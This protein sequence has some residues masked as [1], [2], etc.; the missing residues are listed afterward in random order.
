MKH[1][2]LV[3]SDVHLGGDLVQHLRPHAPVRP[4]AVVRRDEELVALLDWYSA[5]DAHDGGWRLV[6][7][8]DFIDFS[9][10][11]VGL[12]WANYKGQVNLDD[13][14]FG[15]GSTEQASVAKL[16]QVV[17]AHLEV[18]TALARFVARGNELF[19]VRGNH[20]VD[21]FWPRV[22]VAMRDA[23]QSLAEAASG[24]ALRERVHFSDWFY[25]E[26][27]R[28]FVE[29]G[30]NYDAY[31]AHPFPLVPLDPS[32]GT[33]CARSLSDMLKRYVVNP[34]QGLTE[35]GHEDAG[36][37][38]YLRLCVRLGVRRCGAVVGRFLAAVGRAMACVWM[39]DR[40]ICLRF[41]EEQARMLGELA[42]RH[43]LSRS[44]LDHLS[45]H[46][47]RPGT[48]AIS[49]IFA[50]LML[51]QLLLGIAVLLAWFEIFRSFG[52]SHTSLAA[53]LATTIAGYFG[54]SRLRAGRGPVDASG[55][56]LESARRVANRLTTELVVMGHSHAPAIVELG[57]TA[58]YM[59]L[60]SWAE[61]DP[62]EG[63]GACP[64]SRTHLV[65]PA[66]SITEARLYRWEDG[67]PLEYREQPAAPLRTPEAQLDRN[68]SNVETRPT[69]LSALSPR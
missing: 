25:Y 40:A 60:G 42:E 3:I 11:C 63:L 19:F 34:T 55:A 20:D 61:A 32:D 43:A 44:S 41:A 65:V 4:S 59:N 49:T 36:I 6:I 62:S 50:C 54:S 28:V 56:L 22:Q 47:Q 7:A 53:A 27:G 21:L 23:L 30:H 14:T 46:W 1:S 64:A 45:A 52:W 16:E 33:R 24:D 9:G 58:R 39:K 38:D 68:E 8:G 48:H 51:D 69:W 29:H 67:R 31:C 10:M 5:A 2:L 26:P 18:F 15:L 12:E 66:G 57:G 37:S 17:A 35:T 13:R